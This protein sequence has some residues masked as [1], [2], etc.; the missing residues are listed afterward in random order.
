MRSVRC[1]PEKKWNLTAAPM[2]GGAEPD[3]DPAAAGITDEMN[4][5]GFVRPDTDRRRLLL[6]RPFLRARIPAGG[7]CEPI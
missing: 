1:D 6:T 5:Q 2:R 7:A 4:T 3:T